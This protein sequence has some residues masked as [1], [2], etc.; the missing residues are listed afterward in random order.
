MI[1][2]EILQLELMTDNEKDFNRKFENLLKFK[3]LKIISFIR[4]D[5]IT[6]KNSD[7][8]YN[9]EKKFI[10]SKIK[11]L[12]NNKMLIILEINK[13]YWDN[14]PQSFEIYSLTLNNTTGLY[15]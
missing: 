6:V 11:Y 13:V 2:E 7:Y 12:L 8:P 4:N 3:K 9:M 15:N 10:N 5:K 14:I 1:K